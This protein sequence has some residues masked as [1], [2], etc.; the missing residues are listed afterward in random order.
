[1]NKVLILK[2]DGTKLGAC[3]LYHRDAKSNPDIGF[4]F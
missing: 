3:R 4:V 2:E 1:M